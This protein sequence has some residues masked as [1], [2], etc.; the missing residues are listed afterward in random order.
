MVV[1]GAVMIVGNGMGMASVTS[2]PV[3]TSVNLSERSE[4]EGV[5][6]I[7]GGLLDNVGVSDTRGGVR[8]DCSIRHLLGFPR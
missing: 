8:L 4:G 2:G 1:I 7:E 3:E 5:T 6:S